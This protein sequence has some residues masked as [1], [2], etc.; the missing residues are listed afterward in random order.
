MISIRLL[1]AAV[2]A[3]VL[4]ACG[5]SDPKTLI[6]EGQKALGSG[7]STTALAKFTEASAALKP[8]DA[9]FLDAKMGMIEALV[10]TAT[11]QATDEFLALAKSFPDQIGEKQFIYIGGQMISSRKYLEAIALID[12]GIK[13]FGPEATD[14]RSMIERI[15][16]E[17]AND[18]GVIDALAGLGYA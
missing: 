1:A 5:S 13:R 16:Q 18:K 17:A 3:T 6:A 14:L 4:V 10:P 7:D 11:K 9:Q 2:L 8:G 12:A 15:K